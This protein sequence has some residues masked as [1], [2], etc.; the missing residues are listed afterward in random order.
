MLSRRS[1]KT[2]TL[3]RK[4]KNIHLLLDDRLLNICRKARFS[5][6]GASSNSSIFTSTRS[7]GPIC[8]SWFSTPLTA[9]LATTLTFVEILQEMFET[10]SPWKGSRILF[11]LT[12]CEHTAYDT[13]SPPVHVVPD[14]TTTT[15]PNQTNINHQFS[16]MACIS[17]RYESQS[18]RAIAKSGSEYAK[19]W[20]A[21][22]APRI[23]YN[24]RIDQ[25]EDIQGVRRYEVAVLFMLKAYSKKKKRKKENGDRNSINGF[26]PSSKCG[27]LPPLGDFHT[28]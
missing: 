3:S 18:L 14:R 25:E 17:Q 23:R 24:M 12:A 22:S 5:V 16:K 27:V 4:M 11:L 8:T 6:S 21:D 20:L 26:Q 10:S 19:A 15:Q 1:K 7:F 9:Q 28:R 2:Q 13:C